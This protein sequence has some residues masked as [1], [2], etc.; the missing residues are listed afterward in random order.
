[1]GV[2]LFLD[3]LRSL[4]PFH[5]VRL[6]AKHRCGEDALKALPQLT[7]DYLTSTPG[8]FIPADKATSATSGSPSRRR[9][10]HIDPFPGVGEIRSAVDLENA[11]PSLEG[12]VGEG[13]K[14]RVEEDGDDIEMYGSSEEEFTVSGNS[15]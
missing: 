6:I 9:G 2:Q 3:I 4:S 7:E 8:L 5:V 11:G 14:D 12:G 15:R 1:M 10:L 13:E